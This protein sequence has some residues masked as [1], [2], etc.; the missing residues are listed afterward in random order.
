VSRTFLRA[1]RVTA[2]SQGEPVPHRK[3]LL[4]SPSTRPPFPIAVALRRTFAQGYSL[5]RLRHDAFAGV[6]V[7]IV[8][9][10][11]SMALAIAV[12]MTNESAEHALNDALNRVTDGPDLKVRFRERLLERT[13]DGHPA[14]LDKA[15]E[16]LGVAG[17]DD[18]ACDGVDALTTV[19]RA[20][21]ACL[22]A[23]L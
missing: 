15:L 12:G 18:Q 4:T 21:I 19:V 14:V 7:G 22:R 10:P 9:L 2:T 13:R 17:Y 11:L 3:S 8:A 20:A 16:A 5:A 23:G 1:R 6:V